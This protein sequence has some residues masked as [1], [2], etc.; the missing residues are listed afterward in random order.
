MVWA[1]LHNADFL[2]EALGSCRLTKLVLADLLLATPRN[3]LG[4]QGHI[5][6]RLKVG[7]DHRTLLVTECLALPV[8]VPLVMCL[9]MSVIF[10][11]RVVKIAIQPVGLRDH[12]EE[13]RHL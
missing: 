11:E 2:V 8:R 7:L 4:L 1:H 12:T 5:L 13:E 10:V 3:H 6:T 9:V